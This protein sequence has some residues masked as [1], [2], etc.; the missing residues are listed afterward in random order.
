MSDSGI[1][2]DAQLPTAKIEGV[3]SLEF[4]VLLEENHEWSNEITSNPVEN[5]APVS[6]HIIPNADKLRL[7]IMIGDTSIYA[8]VAE[9]EERRTQKAFDVLRQLHDDRKPVTVYTKFRVYDNMGISHIGIP[10][11]AANGDSLTVPIEFQQIRLVDTQTVKVP[12]GIS[13]KANK[14]ATPALQKKTEPQKNAGAKQPVAP[15]TSKT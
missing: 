12:A 7:T 9:G 8:D 4:D 13:K 1:I 11:S 3:T 5:G 6:D 2:Y 10:R 14:K 15:K